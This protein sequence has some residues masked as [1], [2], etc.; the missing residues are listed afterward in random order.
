M[1]LQRFWAAAA[2]AAL[3]AGQASAEP[4]NH[5][6]HS[7]TGGPSTFET[8]KDSTF[9]NRI[10]PSQ[11]VNPSRRGICQAYETMINNGWRRHNLL[12]KYDFTV[13]GSELTEAGKLKVQWTLNQAPEQRRNLFVERGADQQQTADR[14][15]TVQAYAAGMSPSVGQAMVQ[16][17]HIRDEGHPAAGVDAVFTGF[18][19]GQLPPVLPQSTS[20][21]SGGTTSSN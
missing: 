15:A 8:W 21:G 5:C 1:K 3:V 10:W 4:C 17:T 2:S 19:Q 11:Y 13:E 20:G 12:G 16:E 14:I 9:Q 18:R 7:V 6:K